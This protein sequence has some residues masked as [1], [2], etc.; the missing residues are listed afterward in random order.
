MIGLA[1]PGA[2]PLEAGQTDPALRDASID[3]FRA[4]MVAAAALA[5]AGAAIAWFGISDR[6][7]RAAAEQDAAPVAG[8]AGAA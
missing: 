5:F 3:A 4:G 1:T 7:A 6:A 8:R 2:V